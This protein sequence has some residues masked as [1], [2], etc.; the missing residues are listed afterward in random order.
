VRDTDTVAR[1]GGDEFILLLTNIKL[2]VGIDKV[3]K[4]ILESLKRPY[5]LNNHE[6]TCISA[7]IGVTTCPEDADD[8]SSLLKNADRA[9][10]LAKASGRNCWRSYA[11]VCEADRQKEEERHVEI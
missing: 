6:V 10:Y 5:S 4:K 8:I 1:F 7:S 11:D 3:T 2:D 9:M